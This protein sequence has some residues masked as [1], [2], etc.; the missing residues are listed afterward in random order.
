MRLPPL[1]EI[2]RDKKL[3]KKYKIPIRIVHAEIQLEREEKGG[4]REAWPR[5]VRPV[6]VDGDGK[7]RDGVDLLADTHYPLLNVPAIAE[8]ERVRWNLAQPKREP[9][10]ARAVTTCPLPACGDAQLDLARRCPKCGYRVKPG[11]EA[12]IYP[13]QPE[14]IK[15]CQRTGQGGE[16]NRVEERLGQRI[17]VKM[18]LLAVLTHVERVEGPRTRKLFESLASDAWN[19]LKVKKG[20]RVRPPSIERAARATGMKRGQAFARWKKVHQW[21]IGMRTVFKEGGNL[22]N[23]GGKINLKSLRRDRT[24]RKK[25]FLI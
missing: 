7:T 4:K 19:W 21:G 8:A 20:Q 17:D 24:N 13:A 22:L 14:E 5:R 2:I 1:E 11:V 12:K 18:Q 6:E 25:S 15:V 9:V 3:T 10:G 16:R 23:G